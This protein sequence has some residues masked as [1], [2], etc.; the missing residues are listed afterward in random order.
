MGVHLGWWT[1]DAIDVAAMT[2][3]YEGLTGWARLHEEPTGRWVWLRPEPSSGYGTSL[4][5]YGD[6]TTGPKTNKNRAHLDLAVRQDALAEVVGRVRDLGGDRTDIGQGDRVAWEVVADVEGNELCLLPTRPRDDPG[7]V[8]TVDAVTLDA[9][10]VDLVGSFWQEL[11][12]WQEVA[13][14]EGSVRLRAPDADAWELLV[15]ASPDPHEGKIRLHPDLLAEG[16]PGDAG[17]RPVE[18]ERARDL[19]ATRAD[20]GQGEVPWTVLADPEGN[21]FCVLDPYPDA[22]SPRSTGHL[23]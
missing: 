14:N 18:V 9:D 7:P 19:G 21:E 10:D 15:L 6:H 16:E 8:V 5:V 20:I 4:L 13:R 22:P 23:R 17:R 11:L 3:F 2:R 12:G 1:V